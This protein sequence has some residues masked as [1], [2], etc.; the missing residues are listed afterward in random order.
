MV[1]TELIQISYFPALGG[2]RV[3]LLQELRLLT[4]FQLIIHHMA[5]DLG[6]PINVTDKLFHRGDL[7]S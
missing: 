4:D 1:F 3:L 2:D 6:M 7:D 5:I